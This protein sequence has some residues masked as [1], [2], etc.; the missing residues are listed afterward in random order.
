MA[1]FLRTDCKHCLVMGD[2]N[3]PPQQLWNSGWPTYVRG[4][5]VQAPGAF[6]N[7]GGQG[8]ILDYG[9]VSE[10]LAASV[11]LELDL[12]GPWVPHV[13]IKGTLNIAG[14]NLQARMLT[15]VEPL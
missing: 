10:E 4:A 15:P 7:S 8:R 1:G 3:L 13:G 5:I 6:T 11:E 14:E 2:W 9:V 12:R